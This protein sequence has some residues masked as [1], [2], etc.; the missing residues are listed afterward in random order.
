M[1]GQLDNVKALAKKAS[2]A[3]EELKGGDVQYASRL[4][5]LLRTISTEANWPGG[6]AEL[7][8]QLEQLWS[9]DPGPDGRVWTPDPVTDPVASTAELIAQHKAGDTVRLRLSYCLRNT[10][11]EQKVIILR[12]IVEDP[13]VLQHAAEDVL[14]EARLGDDPTKEERTLLKALRQSVYGYDSSDE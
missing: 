9:C 2:N 13:D 7:I 1:S 11:R 10:N 4:E 8:A 12:M 5:T 14:A 6:G 3:L